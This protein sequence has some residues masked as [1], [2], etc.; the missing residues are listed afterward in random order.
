MLLKEIKNIFHHEL[1][2]LYSKEEVNSFFYLMVDHYL[3]L[4][5][6]ILALQ[7]DF[8]ISRTEEQPF[9]QGLAKLRLENPIQYILGETYFFGLK[10]HVNEHVLIPRPETEELVGWIISEFG[11][12]NS[13][14]GILDIGTGSGNIATSLAK[15]L[16]HAKIYA[17]DVS[18]DILEIAKQNAEENKVNIEFILDNILQLNTLDRTFDIIVSNPPYVRELEKGKIA[19]N[20]KKY[21]PPSALFVTDDAPLIFYNHIIDFASKNLVT[22]GALYFEINQYLG[23]ETQQLLEDQNFSEIEIRKDLFEN[24]RM[25]KGVFNV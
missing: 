14:L 1:D 24:D 13:E 2:A 11:I 19:N 21:E 8:I 6:Y 20:V 22:G 4:G 3:G 18:K 5:R 10:F 16:P 15:H 25:L 23:K 7:P 9:F 17:L 12:Q